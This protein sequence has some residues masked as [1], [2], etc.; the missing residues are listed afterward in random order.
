MKMKKEIFIVLLVQFSLSSSFVLESTSPSLPSAHNIE[1]L[2]DLL[3][4]EKRSRAT[5]ELAVNDLK[6]ELSAQNNKTG[7]E[8][9]I[10]KTALIKE[11]SNRRQ[12]EQEYTRLSIEF[13][14]LSMNHEELKMRNKELE[15]KIYNLT[16]EVGHD[17]SRLSRVE[18]KA[19]T[20][21][22]SFLLS[23]STNKVD[24]AAHYA[25][26]LPLKQ[27]QGNYYYYFTFLS[28]HLQLVLFCLDG[29]V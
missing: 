22:Q 19:N 10:F 26:L 16:I 5:L 4:D 7:A 3:L 9:E 27:K 24:I 11:T 17:Q 23:V 2:L 1:Q 14:N 15:E 18:N 21:N 28:Y 20:M 25:E 29:A 13:H 8:I 6:N 12:L